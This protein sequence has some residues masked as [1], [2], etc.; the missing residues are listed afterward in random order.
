MSYTSQLTNNYHKLV[1]LPKILTNP[2]FFN[3]GIFNREN[4]DKRKKEFD[5]KRTPYK[6][7]FA[8]FVKCFANLSKDSPFLFQFCKL[9]LSNLQ[10][11]NLSLSLWFFLFYFGEIALAR[12]HSILTLHALKF[13]RRRRIKEKK[14]F[15][16]LSPSLSKH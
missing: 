8:Q 16:K 10:F 7:Y 13:E 11:P 6:Y 3:L 15:S 4:K 9:Y 12:N 5:F 14:K 1:F 2:N